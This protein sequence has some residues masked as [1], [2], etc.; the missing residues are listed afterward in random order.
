MPNEEWYKLGSAANFINV[1][2]IDFREYQFNII[3]KIYEGRNTIVILP[4]GLGKTLIGIF[5]IAKAL[6][7]GKRALFLAPTKPLSEQHFSTLT[8][9]LKLEPNEIL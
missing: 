7:E 5:A 9:T 2:A 8:S 4:T 6:A 1:D 3:R